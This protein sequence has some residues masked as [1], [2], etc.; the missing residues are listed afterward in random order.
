M[1]RALADSIREERSKY[2]LQRTQVQGAGV[3]ASISGHSVEF[4]FS[5]VALALLDVIASTHIAG[6][7][8]DFTV[9]RLILDEFIPSLGYAAPSTKLLSLA[10]EE[11][12]NYMKQHQGQDF[13]IPPQGQVSPVARLLI[14]AS[15]LRICEDSVLVSARSNDHAA[16]QNALVFKFIAMV[17]EAT[18]GLIPQ[19]PKSACQNF[20]ECFATWLQGAALLTHGRRLNHTMNDAT[21][22]HMVKMM[23]LDSVR[24][25]TGL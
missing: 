6:D 10:V 9:V 16:Q 24:Q 21:Q 5:E 1:L 13:V 2:A 15:F 12:Y 20:A 18:K 11:Y 22:Q 23:V 25:R 14:C 17:K 19:D 4:V 8:V 7:D 3:A